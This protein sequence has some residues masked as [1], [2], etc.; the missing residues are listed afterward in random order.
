MAHT[1]KPPS[2]FYREMESRFFLDVIVCYSVVIL[3][4]LAS[5]NEMLLICRGASAAS[6]AV[7][8]VFTVSLAA[9]CTRR[10]ACYFL[11]SLIFLSW[12]L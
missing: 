2:V 10:S 3:Q 9:G 4:Q 7:F 6:I 12:L 11:S 8:R 1:I 5:E